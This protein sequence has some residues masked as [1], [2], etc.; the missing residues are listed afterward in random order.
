MEGEKAKKEED[1]DMEDAENLVKDEEKEKEREKE[2]VA[3]KEGNQRPNERRDWKQN[4]R[5]FV[6]VLGA[7]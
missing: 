5:L 6:V 3:K 7:P 1:D 4:G 2:K